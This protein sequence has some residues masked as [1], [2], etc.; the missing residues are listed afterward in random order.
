MPCKQANPDQSYSKQKEHSPEGYSLISPS[1]AQVKVND[2]LFFTPVSDYHSCL[3][4]M[5]GNAK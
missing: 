2:F 5:E 3:Q 4:K 1:P